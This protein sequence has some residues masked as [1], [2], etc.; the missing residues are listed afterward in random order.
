M[1]RTTAE[2]GGNAAG[3]A[4]GQPVPLVFPAIDTTDEAEARRLVQALSGLV[5]GFKLGLGLFT[6]AGPQAVARIMEEA[7]APLFLDLK[8]HDIPATV[9][10]A[11][12]AAIRLRPAF[13]TVHALGGA[14]MLTA[15]AEAAR[16]EAERLGVP[17]LRLLAVT[18]LTSLDDA[19]LETLGIGDGVPEAV[20]RLARL[21]HASGIDG[22][23]CAARDLPALRRHLPRHF[24]LVVP[25]I[26][27]DWAQAVDDQKRVMTPA[28]AAQAGA[29]VLVIGRPIT[30]AANCGEAARRIAAELAQVAGPAT[31][32]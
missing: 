30:A 27:P 14:A 6:A 1:T 11:V 22:A 13:L 21:A 7:P 10:M 25:G 8:L 5:G 19:D 23:V 29:D 31:E 2:N 18:I 17:P 15:A 28:E 20:L 4:L 24:A 9:A 26:R 3:T 32:T 12:R 16:T